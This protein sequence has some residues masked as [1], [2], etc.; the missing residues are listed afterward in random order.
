MKPATSIDPQEV[1]FY[2]RLA[3][4]WWDTAGPFWPIH[5]LNALRVS[6]VAA[7]IAAH[8]RETRAGRHGLNGL[9]VV[10]IGCGGGVLSESVARLGAEVVGID[11]ADRNLRVARLHASRSGLEIEYRRATA[12]QL[13]AADDRFDVVL[14]M[15]VVEHVADL[16]AFMAACST[17]VRPGG[18]MFIATINRTPLAW[19]T[20]IIGAEYVLRWLPRGTHHWRKLRKPDEL[21]ALLGRGGLRVTDSTGVLVNPLSR[22]MRFSRF[23]G[24]NY[25]LTAVKHADHSEL[26]PA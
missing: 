17:L 16:E 4:T 9:R 14:N 23:T 15:E 13:A 19:L 21:T 6:Y 22:R 5:T 20:A 11:V 10:D 26:H 2:E 1:A 24:V 25:M 3:H 18:M 8:F 7:Q 12:E